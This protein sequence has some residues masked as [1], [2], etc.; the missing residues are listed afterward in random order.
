MGRNGGTALVPL[1]ACAKDALVLARVHYNGH[2]SGLALPAW[3]DG[4]IFVSVFAKRADAALW[5]LFQVFLRAGCSRLLASWRATAP[6]CAYR[7]F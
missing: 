1:P 3:Q 4:D 2:T 5:V 6:S 7:S